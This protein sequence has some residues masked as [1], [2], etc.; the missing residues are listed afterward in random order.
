MA[1]FGLRSRTNTSIGSWLNSGFAGLGTTTFPI[2]IQYLVLAG[3]GAG[4]SGGSYG[5]AG[6]GGA[7]GYR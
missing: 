4:G 7:G 6:G 5:V 2:S 3:G 1:S